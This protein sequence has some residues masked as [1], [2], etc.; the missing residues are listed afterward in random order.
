H[1]DE[2][3]SLLGDF[4]SDFVLVVLPGDVH[5]ISS[6]V[7]HHTGLPSGNVDRE[8]S[9]C[10]DG[11]SRLGVP[12]GAARHESGSKQEGFCYANGLHDFLR[13]SFMG[14]LTKRAALAFH[15]Q[16]AVFLGVPST[17]SSAALIPR[18]GSREG[19]GR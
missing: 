10:R 7:E 9:G 2:S 8:W 13:A 15:G 11:R 1:E 4:S 5:P 3:V 12:L 18:Q 19:T 14:S 16:R 6:G 17:S